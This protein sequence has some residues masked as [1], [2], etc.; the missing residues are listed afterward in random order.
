MI[1][2]CL[3]QISLPA[4]GT[5]ENFRRQRQTS[6]TVS[7]TKSHKAQQSLVSMQIAADGHNS[8][9]RQAAG[10]QNVSWNYDQSAVV[11]TLHL[12]EVNLE[13]TIAFQGPCWCLIRVLLTRTLLS[14]VGHRKRCSLAEISSVWA[15]CYAS[16]KKSSW[17]VCLNTSSFLFR[18][19]FL[20]SLFQVSNEYA[21]A[22]F[23]SPSYLLLCLRAPRNR[24]FSS[25]Y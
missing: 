5:R 3:L 17:L 11:A 10:I 15:H 8:G 14:I 13:P 18:T 22:S 12:S 19:S 9:V 25:Q 2:S 21:Q 24:S 7:F 6:G 1:K 16:G 20:L 23:V 4:I